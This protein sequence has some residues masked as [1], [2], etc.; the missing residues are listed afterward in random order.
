M[1]HH[2]S[3]LKDWQVPKAPFPSPSNNFFVFIFKLLQRVIS[4]ITK[5]YIR[6]E[7]ETQIRAIKEAKSWPRI[8][9]SVSIT[10]PEKVSLGFD[11][12]INPGFVAFAAGG[13]KIG[14]H[15]HFGH[16]VRIMTQNHNFMHPQCLPYDKVRISKPVVIHDNVWIG[17]SVCIAPGVTIGEGSVIGMAS[18]VTK[19][20][21][22][23]AIVGGAPAKVI[24]YRDEEVYWN[25]KKE[26]KFLDWLEPGC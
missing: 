10:S 11:V 14:N 24:K 12:N 7:T 5:Y 2:D 1:S 6:L 25:L 17:D 18:V 8:K 19:D 23:L 9:G 3:D 20:V 26:K 16:N 15:V 4:P 13:L 22:P 21:P